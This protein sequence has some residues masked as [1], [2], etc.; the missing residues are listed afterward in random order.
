MF[1]ALFKKSLVCALPL[2]LTLGAPQAADLDTLAKDAG[3]TR[4]ALD[5]ALKQAVYQQKIIDAITRPAESKPWWQFRRIFV[6]RSRIEAGVNFYLANE[7]L[8]ARAE[9]EFGVPPE[10][11]C[12]IMAVET[13]FGKNM[14]SWR[15]LDALYTL[16]FNY[17][18]RGAYFSKEFAQFVRLCQRENWDIT[19][20]KGSYAGAMGMGQFMPTSYLE[21]AVDFDGDGHENLF[22][23]SADAIGSVANYFQVHK[24]QQGRGIYYPAHIGSADAQALMDKEWE[25]T[26]RDLY[27]AGVSTKVALE[28]DENVRLYA[29]E[30]EDGTTDYGVALNNFRTIMRYNTS[31]LYA[32]VVYEIGEFIRMGH[33]R[34]LEAQGVIVQPKGRRP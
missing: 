7:A 20:V 18:K 30:L 2:L 32:R 5:S 33:A 23:N 24:W 31:K 3:I 15:V 13:L 25:L 34:A 19:S 26:A 8:L 22:T 28:P 29:F 14:G 4:A 12:A 9:Q 21:Y 16:G 27:K 17:P 10:I 11:V 1:K 6:T